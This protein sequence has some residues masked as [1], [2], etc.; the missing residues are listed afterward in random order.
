MLFNSLSFA[1]FFILLTGLHFSLPHRFRWILILAASYYFY[2]CWNVGYILLIATST[3]ITWYAGL[4]IEGALSNK[5][6]KHFLI[7]SLVANLGALLFFKYFNFFTTSLFQISAKFNLFTGYEAPLLH[8]MLPVGISFYTFQTV[9]YTIDIYQGK[10][11]PEKHLGIFAL[12]VAFWPRIVAGPIERAGKLIPQFRKVI[13][14]DYSNTTDALR[15][16]LWG[17]IKKVVIADQLAVYVNQVFDNCGDYTGFPLII[18]SI[19]FT[20][21]IYCDFS[22]YSDM[23]IGTAKVMGYELTENFRHPYFAASLREFWQRWHISLSTWF[24]DYVYIPLGGK[25]V[26][27]WRFYY[28]LFI[29][30]LV[31]GLWHGANWT[32][33]IWGGLHGLYLIIENIVEEFFSN[34]FKTTWNS[35]ENTTF[36]KAIRVA[37]TLFLVNY[38][39]I[40]FRANTVSDAFSI[41]GKMFIFDFK[42]SSSLIENI[43]VVEPSSFILSL[44]LILFLIVVE[45][46]E[47]TIKIENY[48]GNLPFVAR[49]SIY[50]LGLWAV[51]ISTVFGVKQEFIYFQF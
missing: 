17:M 26:V 4:K 42:N 13:S 37:I 33:V 48:V 49:W 31:S 20:I 43:V 45:F 21:Q 40:F 47:Q 15:L 14:F 19:F 44:A 18:A 38:A 34:I 2:M 35:I 27:K 24:R 32:F 25:R 9:S 1:L 16:V 39:W 7:A 41:T 11:E 3:L 8:I 5:R 29:T 6:K 10:I 46:K 36:Y 30:F 51:I 12:Y 22:G 50:T 23:A 28:N